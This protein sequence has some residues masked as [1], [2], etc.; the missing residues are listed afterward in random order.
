MKGNPGQTQLDG[1][2][3]SGMPSPDGQSPNQ[4]PTPTP[5]AS[6]HQG[7]GPQQS[8]P[9]PAGSQQNGQPS[10]HSVTPQPGGPPGTHPGMMPPPPNS[11]SPPS[12]WGDM[13]PPSSAHHPSSGA[14]TQVSHNSYTP[15]Y[16]SMGWYAQN[17]LQPQPQHLLT[18]WHYF[19]WSKFYFSYLGHSSKMWRCQFVPCTHCFVNTVYPNKDLTSQMDKKRHVVGMTSHITFCTETARV[20]HPELIAGQFVGGATG[21][22]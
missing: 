21:C 11:V 4:P 16:P 5:P 15:G 2:Q 12:A 3:G 19:L 9:G 6:Q 8:G 17:C 13:S 1:P 22:W 10:G 20:F 14:A 18:W 7:P